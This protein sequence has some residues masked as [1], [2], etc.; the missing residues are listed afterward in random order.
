[1][2]SPL[3]SRSPDLQLL[4]REGYE[5][6]IRSGYLLVKRVPFAT[7]A[8]EVAFG[9][10]ISELSAS[11][12]A[13][14][15]PENHVAFFA[16]GI[17][18][19][20][21]G[22]QLSK[23]INSIGESRLAD[24]LTADCMFSSKPPD[25]YPDYYAKMTAYANMIS[26]WA[27]AI[28]PNVT[29]RPLVPVQM[30]ESESVFRYL[31]TASS[32][33][34]ISLITGKLALPKVAIAGVGGTGGYVLDLIAKT[35]VSEIHLFDGDLFYAHNA[36]RAPGAA[37]VE[38]L[39]AMPNKAEYHRD[40]YSAM[41]RGIIAHPYH[42]DESNI[43]ELQDMTF[44]FVTMDPGPG[45]KFI[46]EKL[47]EYALPFI[48]TGMGVRR[49][50][51]MLRGIVTATTSTPGHRAHIW[52]NKRITFADGGDD[53]DHNIQI[54]DLN[55]LNAVFAVIRWKK[56]YGFYADDEHEMFTAYTIAANQL[57]NADQLP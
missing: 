8:G 25:G 33:A 44:V 43:G 5:I 51:D 17:P 12:T 4:L 9:T 57:L 22:N 28:D 11:G 1:M 39:D 10:L 6:E 41:R 48:D 38:D 31:D 40:R 52:A 35:P 34:Q 50:G 21:R 24:G 53:Y 2:S 45:K 37:S 55:M 32:R 47:E 18:C 49:M 23:I 3:V 54:A 27:E 14:I 20:N 15:R 7:S 36:F 30:T 46:V 56:L 42:I 26:G 19:D 13:T 16:G 29:A